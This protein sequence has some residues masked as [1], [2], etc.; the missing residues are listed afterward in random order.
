MSC[1]LSREVL[2]W[3]LGLDLSYAVKNPKRDFANGF[4]YAEILSR[5]YP[6]D[7]A[8]HSFE[9]VA[10]MERKKSNW[11]LL[12][13]VIKRKRIP[14]DRGQI[15]A[16]IA[17]DGDAA[18]E[19][20]QAIFTFIHSPSYDD[21][22]DFVPLPGAAAGGGYGGN[23]QYAA[24]Y[25]AQQQMYGQ[26]PM[27][28]YFG[29]GGAAAG[30]GYAAQ[31]QQQQQQQ[32]AGGRKPR[33]VDFK[34]Y[35]LKDFEDKQYNVKAGKGYW[36]LGKLGPDLETEELQ[37]KREAKEK[38]KRMAE[39]DKEPSARERALQFARNIPKP[40]PKPQ[41]KAA[42]A[43]EVGAVDAEAQGTCGRIPLLSS[44]SRGIIL[45][46][47]MED[48]LKLLANGADVTPFTF[49]AGMLGSAGG[50]VTLG[51]SNLDLALALQTGNI[52]SFIM[53]SLGSG[54]AAPLPLPAALALPSLELPK[55]LSLDV[56]LDGMGNK[57]QGVDLNGNGNSSD[58]SGSGGALPPRSRS[59]R[60][61]NNAAALLADARV[62]ELL[63]DVQQPPIPA[64]AAAAAARNLKREAEQAIAAGT[65]A[66]ARQLKKRDLNR[67]AQRRFRDRQK[68]ALALLESTTQS[69]QREIEALRL[70][71]KLLEEQYRVLMEQ[72]KGL[73]LR[74]VTLQV[75]HMGR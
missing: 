36:Q 39:Q 19:V 25:D 3:I 29:G 61:G 32:Q 53:G 45:W 73:Q 15:E 43:N 70:T 14:I 6:Q 5:Y 64:P 67:E 69:Q 31:A 59:G 16:V 26:A 20:L 47:E 42:T 55:L 46:L 8:M 21:Q 13:K 65:A 9:N 58:P 10:S 72:Y 2:K 34:P 23:G 75:K 68:A 50:S 33:P 54:G 22:P 1:G 48:I 41:K 27:A 37:A 66:G 44:T 63:L 56:G 11:A 52:P 49:P 74:F 38:I 4:L 62:R 12:E 24:Q 7:I 28:M 60:G 51:A 17:A 71:N 30:G 57:G 18:V 40:E 35:D